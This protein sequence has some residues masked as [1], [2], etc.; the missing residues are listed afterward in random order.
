[1][2]E[3]E[4]ILIDEGLNAIDIQLER[5]ILN[6]IFSK[7]PNKTI[8]IVSHRMENQDL[9]HQVIHF[10]TKKIKHLLKERLYD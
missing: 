2:Q 4:I 10:E 6:N 9:F 1:M 5:K 7:Y 8:I 3:K